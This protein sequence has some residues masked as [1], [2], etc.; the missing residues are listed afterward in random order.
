MALY[1]KLEIA[2]SPWLAIL[3]LAIYSTAVVLKVGPWMC[4]IHI[5]WELVR[6]AKSCALRWLILCVNLTGLRD[7]QIADKTLFLRVF[8]KRLVF[9]SV[10]EI[11]KWA[12]IIQSVK[13]LNR[14]ERQRKS[15]FSLSLSSWTGM[16]ILS[17]PWTWGLLV[18]GPSNFR[19]S[20]ECS[21]ISFFPFSGLL[22]WSQLYH[23]LS[24]RKSVV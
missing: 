22:L 23:Q 13:G 21:F 15:K 14:P 2:V 5:T 6:N 3:F 11:K 10:D 24:D 20:Q 16:F 4:I 19:T 8:Q 7:T 18:I 17:C 1:N 12:G 9:E